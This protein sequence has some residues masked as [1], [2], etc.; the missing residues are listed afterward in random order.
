MVPDWVKWLPTVNAGLNSA[1]TVLLLRGW[2]QIRRGQRAEH[3]RTMLTA[4]VVSAIF[5]VCYLIYHA[6]LQHY[7]GS[8]SK[9]FE[10][11]GFIRPIYYSILLTHVLLAF[12]VA[13]FTPITIWLGLKAERSEEQLQSAAWARHRK[14]AKV[15]FPIWLY[16]SV[17]GVVIYFLLYHGPTP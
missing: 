8:G 10:G 15:T 2:W 1:A 6:A 3:K 5:L 9:K 14:F 16:V 4:F 11:V 7:T 12:F 17:T 13:V